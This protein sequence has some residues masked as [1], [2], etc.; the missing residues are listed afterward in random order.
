MRREH[1]MAEYLCDWE[2]DRLEAQEIREQCELEERERLLEQQDREENDRL[3][4]EIVYQK[5][6]LPTYDGKLYL[7]SLYVE[8][9][10]TFFV[11][12]MVASAGFIS[13]LIADVLLK[14]FHFLTPM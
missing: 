5:L 6:E 12:L 2:L 14:A 11:I 9:R 10:D 1:E 8:A 3:C 4:R 13:L 7:L